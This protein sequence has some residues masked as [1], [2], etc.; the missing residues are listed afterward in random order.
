MRFLVT[1]GAGF[2]GSAVCR[3]LITS[4]AG[5]VLNVDKLTYSSDLRSLR[6]IEQ[7][8]DYRFVQADIGDRAAMMAILADWQPDIVLHLAAET[9]VDR[10]ITGAAAFIETN[11]VGTFH[12]L[13]ACRDYHD[14]LAEPAKTAFRFL[15]I[16]T[17][18]VFGSLGPHG[19]F[20]EASP[21]QPNSP[22]SASKAASD[23]LV[24][25][26]FH[27]YG[28]PV[29]TTN[30]S[31][32]YGPHQFPEKL[33]PL[34]TIQAIRRAPMPVYG[35]G[36]NVRDWLHVDDHAQALLCVARHGRPGET[37]AI[38]GNSERT[39]LQIVEAICDHMDA[40][41]PGPS[42]RRN[43]I[44]F[45]ADR[46]GHDARYAIDARKITAEL[47]WAPQHDFEAGLRDTIEWYRHNQAWWEPH[48]K[49]VYTAAPQGEL[50]GDAQDRPT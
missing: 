8:H 5:Q 38:G 7:H 49:T 25:A 16:S 31:N 43:A 19:A 40:V 21:Y 15:H 14:K 42:A 18:E 13:E 10:S 24:R 20:N 45:V 32:N 29:L 35:T 39:N 17:D 44:H 9:H 1:G 3:H 27:T 26:W 11:I 47:G 41:D 23:H 6:A 37:Y 33:I 30:C 50:I 22:Y 12:L 36:L 28:L 2:I 48:L 46:P 4:G 34:M